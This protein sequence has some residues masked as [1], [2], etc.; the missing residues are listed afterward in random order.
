MTDTRAR[1]VTE[2]NHRLRVQLE[3]E[4]KKREWYE[5]VYNLAIGEVGQWRTLDGLRRQKSD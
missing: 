1:E 4:T 5:R 3:H 2:L